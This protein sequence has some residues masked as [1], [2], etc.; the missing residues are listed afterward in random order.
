MHL[1]LQLHLRLSLYKR[2]NPSLVRAREENTARAPSRCWCVALCH[3]HPGSCTPGIGTAGFRN[4]HCLWVH[5]IGWRLAIKFLESVLTRLL[6]RSFFFQLLLN[7]CSTAC[8]DRHCNITTW[9]RARQLHRQPL[10]QLASPLVPLGMLL[11]PVLYCI[12]L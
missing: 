9:H 1:T 11:Q 8:G 7:Y 5:L 2:N 10:C 12:W 6:A 4:Q 3:C